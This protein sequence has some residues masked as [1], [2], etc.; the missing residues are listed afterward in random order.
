MELEVM[1]KSNAELQ[2]TWRARRKSELDDLRA[3]VAELE[4]LRND[5]CPIPAAVGGASPLPAAAIPRPPE[6]S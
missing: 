5:P 6:T 2:A 4:S 3:R 1:P